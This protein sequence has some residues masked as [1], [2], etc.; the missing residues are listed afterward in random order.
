MAQA[1]ITAPGFDPARF[2]AE[3]FAN[4]LD[5]GLIDELYA[6]TE[7]EILARRT[8]RLEL[9]FPDETIP[10]PAPGMPIFY[11]R[12]LYPR[13]LEFFRAGATHIERLFQA[14]NRV[15]KTV[16]GS[17]ECACHATGRYPHWWA[18]RQFPWAN[19]GW[20]AG[21]TNETTRDIIQKELFGEVTW[22]AG[23]KAFDGTGMIPKDAIISATWKRGVDGLADV[24]KVKHVSGGTSTIGLKSYD[25][26]RRVFQGTAKHWIWLDEEPPADVYGEALIRLMTTKGLML[27]TFT[28]L[29]GLSDVVL[30]FLEAESAARETNR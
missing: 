6:T 12:H 24:V 13:H 27:I 9:F 4:A 28:P 21:D 25:Q 29:L 7:G 5:A 20:A 22:E 17:Y 18:G 26:G 16:A 11:A 30:S 15:G 14:G 23:R 2:D 8:N 1:I 3:Q 19:H 10:S